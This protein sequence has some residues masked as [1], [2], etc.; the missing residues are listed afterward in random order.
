MIVRYLDLSHVRSILVDTT[1]N[2]ADM[3]SSENSQKLQQVLRKSPHHNSDAREH[4]LFQA[5]MAS[6][7]CL[8]DTTVAGSDTDT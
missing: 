5:S 4:I 7:L 1:R 2:F 6:E 8:D 3:Q